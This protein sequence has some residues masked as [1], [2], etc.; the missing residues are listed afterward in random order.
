MVEISLYDGL[1]LAALCQVHCCICLSASFSTS[2]GPYMPK[3]NLEPPGKDHELRDE[4]VQPI[5]FIDANVAAAGPCTRSHGSCAFL[6]FSLA[7][8]N[9]ICRILFGNHLP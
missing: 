8:C 1:W 9:S 3:S 5:R 7:R 2:L 4:T 6:I